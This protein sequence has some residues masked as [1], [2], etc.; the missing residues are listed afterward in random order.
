M[1]IALLAPFTERRDNEVRNLLL[2]GW[3][4]WEANNG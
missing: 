2:G 1:R 4:V 3:I